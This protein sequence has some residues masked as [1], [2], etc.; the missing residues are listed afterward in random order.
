MLSQ[1]RPA[2]VSFAL[3]TILTGIVY[4]AM[5][6]IVANVAFAD[7][8]GGSIISRDGKAVGSSLI[9]QPFSSPGYFWPR[10]SACG[11]DGAAGSGSNFGPANPARAGNSTTRAGALKAADPGNAAPIPVDLLTASASGLDPHISPAAAAYQVER[12]ARAR[13]QSVADIQ[14]MVDRFTEGRGFGILGEARVNVLKLNL[15]LDHPESA[16][17]PAATTASQDHS[18]RQRAFLPE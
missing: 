9:A 8:A 11:Y 5:V 6:T 10:P 16:T 1:L 14:A 18:Y 4:P 13:N 17:K 15:A 12:V 3:L 2:I 7:E